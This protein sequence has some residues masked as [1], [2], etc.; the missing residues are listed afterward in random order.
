M[1]AVPSKGSCRP[2]A[3]V[4]VSKAFATFRHLGTIGPEDNYCINK[5]DG[6]CFDVVAFREQWLDLFQ[7]TLYSSF[8]ICGHYQILPDV[9][10]ACTDIGRVSWGSSL[11]T[12]LWQQS[13]FHPTF[14]SLIVICYVSSLSN[15]HA[16]WACAASLKD[17][18]TL[19]CWAR[20]QRSG[21]QQ[22]AQ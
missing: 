7:L 9:S 16:V 11:P 20:Q 3:G 2:A 22:W 15:G 6:I 17:A 1:D 21:V 5:N 13:W 18:R 12:C 14:L 19:A 10:V 8:S 4:V